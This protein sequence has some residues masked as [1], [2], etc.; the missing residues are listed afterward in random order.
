MQKLTIGKLAEM[1]G[2]SADTLRYYEKMKL[3]T[4]E[5]R[6]PAGYRIYSPDAVHVVRF[7]CRAKALNFTLEE[8]RQLLIMNASD[9]AT[10]AQMLKHTENKIVEAETKIKELKEIKQVLVALAKHCPSNDT[11]TENCPI[12]DYIRGKPLSL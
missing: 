9:K 7:I 8:I 4:A 6:S 1:T 3:L 12:L 10:C 11:P 5:G 2:I